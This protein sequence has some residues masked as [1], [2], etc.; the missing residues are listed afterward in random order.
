MLQFLI[1]NGRLK[2]IIYFNMPAIWSTVLDSNWLD[3]KYETKCVVSGG[4][5]MKIFDFIKFK[6]AD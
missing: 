1:Q 2:A 6:K 3:H 4:C 5:T